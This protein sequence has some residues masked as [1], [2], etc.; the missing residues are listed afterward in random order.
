M[1]FHQTF[2]LNVPVPADLVP[3]LSKG[4][5]SGSDSH[6]PPSISAE[7]AQPVEKQIEEK[8]SIIEASVTQ[9][10]STA[11]STTT[12]EKPQ[13][14]EE[15]SSSNK[16]V[17]T[18]SLSPPKK[19]NVDKNK[20]PFRFNVKATEFKPNPSAPVFV[21]G[22][23]SSASTAK[24]S[25]GEG[26]PFFAGRQLKK[27]TAGEQLTI[28]EA[29]TPPFAKGKE[30]VTPN[31]IGPTWPFG[32][33]QYKYHFNQYTNYEE[34]MFGGYGSPGYPYGYPQYRYAP[35]SLFF[36]YNDYIE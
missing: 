24:S 14:Q 16:S 26:S 11:T 10:P 4:K 35:V 28:A 5:K 22:G 27:G 17:A 25:P 3:L 9:A 21:P 7:L 20:S 30:P 19:E 15:A 34:E 18:S 2:K 13:S 33:K 12:K 31:S 29:F 32:S 1:K 23:A 36:S 6:S 8:K